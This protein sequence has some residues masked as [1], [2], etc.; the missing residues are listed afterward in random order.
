MAIR[1]L[2]NWRIKSITQELKDT[3]KE[4]EKIELR[5]DAKERLGKLLARFEDVI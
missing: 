2:E 3:M 1:T 5:E 4:S